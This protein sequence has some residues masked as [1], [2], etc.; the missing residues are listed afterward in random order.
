MEEAALACQLDPLSPII[1]SAQGGVYVDDRQFEKA[2]EIY[3]K[4][5]ADN[6]AFGHAH[7]G[8]ANAYWALHKYPETIQESA[9]AAR[10]LDDKNGVEVAAGLDAGFRSR[11]WPAALQRAVAVSIAQRKAKAG[12][13]VSPYQIAELYAELGDK[14]HAFEWLATAYQEHDTDLIRLRTDYAMDPLRADPRYAELVR[15]IGFPQ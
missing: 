8:L 11:G 9:M 13:Y 15:K 6:P 3:K 4:V 7:D 2:I 1:G 14:E 12:F 10:L 5:I